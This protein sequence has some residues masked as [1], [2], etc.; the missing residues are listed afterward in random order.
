MKKAMRN[1]DKWKEEMKK[2]IETKRELITLAEKNGFTDEDDVKKDRV[3]RIVDDL[4]ADMDAVILSVENEDDYRALYTLD[5]TP[6]RDPV[7]LPEFSGNDG[8]DFHLFKEE[9]ERGFVQNRTPRAN[10]LSK[11][12]EC[13]SG[14]A[15]MFVPKSMVTTIDEAWDILK[16]SYGDGYRIIKY[17]KDEIMKVGKF[18]KVNEKS[19]GGYSRQ[20]AWFLRVENILKEVLHLGKRYLE[21]SDVAFSFEFISTVIMMFPERLRFKLLDCPGKQG[22]HLQN[23]AL[24]IENLREVAQGLQLIVEA[25]T[26]NLAV[27]GGGGPGHVSRQQGQCPGVRGPNALQGRDAYKRPMRG[28][29]SRNCNMLVTEKSKSK[30]SFKEI[31]DVGTVMK[32]ENQNKIDRKLD[33]ESQVVEKVIDDIPEVSEKEIDNIPEERVSLNDSYV[34]EAAGNDENDLLEDLEDTTADA[35]TSDDLPKLE[36]NASF[37]NEVQVKH[38]LENSKDTN[39][40]CVDATK[41]ISEDDNEGVDVKGQI[42]N[43]SDRESITKD[44]EETKQQLNHYVLDEDENLVA[45]A[46]D[47]FKAKLIN[48]FTEGGTDAKKVKVMFVGTFLK[49]YED[50]LESIDKIV[51][52]NKEDVEGNEIKE[53]DSKS[54]G[55]QYEMRPVYNEETFADVKHEP[56]ASEVFQDLTMLAVCIIKI[57]LTMLNMLLNVKK[58]SCASTRF[59]ISEMS[60]QLMPIIQ[61]KLLTVSDLFKMDLEEEVVMDQTASADKFMVL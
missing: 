27:A 9:V 18:P 33:A 15:L 40:T 11:L 57:I 31:E 39:G 20:I 24:K 19:Q 7:K 37:V 1:I 53:R 2:I 56:F 54:E 46:E 17:R 3:E 12:R 32:V 50:I 43:I 59:P 47:K 58:S 51:D 61:E 8:E 14:V 44:D 26:P 25:S 23:V 38:H 29:K 4:K 6:V 30:P 22:D 13:L 60:S 21:Y 5:I 36:S 28:K 16:K 48:E 34:L 52:E 55:S 49:N 42:S 45:E 10:Q 41:D 35:S